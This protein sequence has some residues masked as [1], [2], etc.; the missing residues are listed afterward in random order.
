MRNTMAGECVFTELRAGAACQNECGYLLKHDYLR[1]P[2]RICPA[3]K[4]RLGDC[5]ECLLVINGITSERVA[6]IVDTI[7]MGAKPPASRCKC[8]GC[9]KRK[10]WLNQWPAPK[11]LAR[12]A[13]F[14]TPSTPKPPTPRDR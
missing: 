2:R 9:N 4:P 13:G 3:Y 10:A 1:M 6:R 14:K 11:W 7:T 5:V 12:M 8:R